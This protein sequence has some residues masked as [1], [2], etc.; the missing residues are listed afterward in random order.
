MNSNFI[1]KNYKE[2]PP[3][4]ADLAKHLADTRAWIESQCV[5]PAEEM[6]SFFTVRENGYDEHMGQFAPCYDVTA[7]QIPADCRK[8]LDLG[9]GT[10]LELDALDR[11]CRAEGRAFP[12]VV[13]VDMTEALVDQLYAK[14]PDKDITVKLGSYFD[15]PFTTEPCGKEE[16]DC[17]VSVESI[18]HFSL[19][20]K[21][22]LFRKV[23]EALK[24]G[25]VFLQ[26]DYFA[27]CEEEVEM[28]EEHW[29]I[30]RAMN[31][32]IGESDFVHIDRPKMAYDEAAVME[33]AGFSE[34][35]YCTVGVEGTLLLIG[36]K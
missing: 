5:R 29:R 1:T 14:H 12:A 24:P 31:S 22:P 13:G 36:K 10:G 35:L 3:L 18:H 15:V 4:R 26:C 6:A 33:N 9:C 27:C 25:G 17:A 11:I 30:R 34:V 23:W 28:N 8:L 7:A 2:L 32:E 20:E 19:E 16:F 21:L